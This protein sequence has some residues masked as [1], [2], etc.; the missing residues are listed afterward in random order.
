MTSP[1]ASR[2]AAQAATFAARG[3]ALWRFTRPHTIIG[4]AASIAGLY[5]IVVDALP[6]VTLRDGLGN[7]AWTLVA[8]FCVN[9][10]I[11]GVN[12]LEDVEIDRVSSPAW[13]SARP[14]RRRRCAS[15]ASRCW[16]R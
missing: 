6:G 1:A 7:L 2:H 15:S 13:R 10:Y 14:T 12:Q 3:G 8:G 9:V 16:P 4:T 5:V 11:V